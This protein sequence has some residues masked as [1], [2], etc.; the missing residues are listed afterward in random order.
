[1]TWRKD[2]FRNVLKS[3]DMQVVKYLKTQINESIL[4]YMQALNIK[5]I[6][7]TEKIN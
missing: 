1:M 5:A 7:T 6:L 2:I 4:T 3:Y